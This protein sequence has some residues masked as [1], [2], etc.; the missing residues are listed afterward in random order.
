MLDFAVALTALVLATPVMVVTAIAIKAHDGGPIFFKHNRVGKDG[1][2]FQV[3][4]FRSMTTDADAQKAEVAQAT[5]SAESDFFKASN[6]PR[7]TP[8]GRYIRRTSIDE[9]PQ[10][11]NVLLRDMSVVGPRPLVPGE[12]SE[13]PNFVERRLLVRPGI[14][15]L[16]Q[17]S[18]RSDMREEDR[19]R[20][21]L[22]YVE[23][24]SLIQDLVIL[25]RTVSAII[26]QRGAY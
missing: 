25:T 7:I 14:T 10:L 9:L 11:F 18:G 22:V 6:D 19:I 2:T 24:W 1:A 20:L 23:N 8:I 4:K 15:G 26:A 13:I 3:W 12:G 16:W 17:V 5:S 21:D